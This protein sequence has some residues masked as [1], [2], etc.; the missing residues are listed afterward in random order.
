MSQY[1][2]YGNIKWPISVNSASSRMVST[3]IFGIDK[4]QK[5]FLLGL[6]KYKNTISI[7]RKHRLQGNQIQR[8]AC[9]FNFQ[10]VQ[11]FITNLSVQDVKRK[12]YGLFLDMEPE[13]PEK[14]R[15]ILLPIDYQIFAIWL[16]ALL[17]ST[18]TRFIRV[19]S[20]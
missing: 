4:P 16:L 9:N 15:Q 5:T 18:V 10:L 7:Y 19:S 13:H 8:Y 3:R 12:R 11:K 1:L 2:K 6:F 20:L 17:R 14:K